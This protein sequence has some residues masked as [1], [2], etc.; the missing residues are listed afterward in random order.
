MRKR[1]LMWL[2]G[3]DDIE[4]YISLLR[5]N[6]DLLDDSIHHDSECIELIEAHKETLETGAWFIKLAKDLIKICE[7]H[8][9]DIDEEIRLIRTEEVNANETLD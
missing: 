1:I 8:G 7:K 2:F 9:I 5:K 4:P 3:T 6:I